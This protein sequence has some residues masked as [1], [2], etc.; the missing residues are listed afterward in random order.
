MSSGA[1]RLTERESGFCPRSRKREDE[2]RGIYPL[3]SCSLRPPC[4]ESPDSGS[5]E[6]V[7]GL[8][9]RRA[10]TLGRLLQKRQ[11]GRSA[12]P[13][14]PIQPNRRRR[15]TTTPVR[16]NA[17]KAQVVGSG[18]APTGVQVSAPNMLDAVNEDGL[19][20]PTGALKPMLI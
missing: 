13:P 15:K 10:V 16:L 7:N 17:S 8:L 20:L 14:E 12:P 2:N 19:V 3:H 9:Q 6:F 5:T 11:Q 1:L 18:T 4:E